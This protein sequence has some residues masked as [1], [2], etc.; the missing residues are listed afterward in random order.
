LIIDEPGVIGTLAN[1]PFK[2][3][4][5]RDDNNDSMNRLRSIVAGKHHSK[6]DFTN[7]ASEENVIDGYQIIR[8]GCGSPKA[9]AKYQDLMA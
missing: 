3:K 4:T 1:N 7:L 2:K 9:A 5:V 8:A 6:G